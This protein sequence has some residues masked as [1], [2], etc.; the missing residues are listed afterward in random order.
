MGLMNNI[1]NETTTLWQTITKAATSATS[2][3][4]AEVGDDVVGAHDSLQLRPTQAG[5][6]FLPTL[7]DDIQPL[8]ESQQLDFIRRG[9]GKSISKLILKVKD[10]PMSP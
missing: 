3:A 1:I 5:A 2:D 6:E 9:L 7:S 10:S 4:N 8:F